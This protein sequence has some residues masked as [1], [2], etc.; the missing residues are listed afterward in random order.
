MKH[1]VIGLLAF[2]LLGNVA[3]QAATIEEI[4]AKVAKIDKQ[5]QDQ[6]LPSI[7]TDYN[8]NGPTEGVPPQFSFFFD[9]E[10]NDY[11]TLKL[12]ACVAHIGRETWSEDFFYYFDENEKIMKYVEKR[13]DLEPTRTAII[14][15]SNG[16]VLWENGGTRIA[17]EKI[18]TLFKALSEAGNEIAR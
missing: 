2:L 10:T 4:N 17:P 1:I 9:H 18:K 8:Y 3:L 15:N 7:E 11:E 12:V 13:N 6:K 5:I 16:R 14:Y